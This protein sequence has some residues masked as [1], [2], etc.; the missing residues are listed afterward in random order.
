MG[1]TVTVVV[2]GAIGTAVAGA[3]IWRAERRSAGSLIAAQVT[4]A[5]RDAIDDGRVSTTRQFNASGMA[6]PRTARLF[7]GMLATSA[8]TDKIPTPIP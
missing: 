7:A 1:A 8:S 6:G 5:R 3:L 2:A 4:F